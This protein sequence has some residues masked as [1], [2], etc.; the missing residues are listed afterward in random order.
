MLR[1]SK[2]LPRYILL[3]VIKSGNSVTHGPHHVAHTFINRSL[4]ELFFSKSFIP[5]SS[6]ISTSTGSLAHPSLTSAWC[7]SFSAHLIEQPNTL[8]VCTGTCLLYTSDA[9]DER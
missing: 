9:A 1:N 7:S 5:L 3:I 4:S 2:S 6:I 8:V